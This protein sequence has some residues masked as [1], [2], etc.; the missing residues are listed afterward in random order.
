MSPLLTPLS[1]TICATVGKNF[2]VLLVVELLIY[3]KKC[4]LI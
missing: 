1:F 4:F 3:G 2:D